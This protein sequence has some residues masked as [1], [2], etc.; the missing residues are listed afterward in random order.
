MAFN[1]RVFGYQGL[2]QIPLINPRQYSADSV[3]QLIQPYLWGQTVS[4]SAV[5]ASTSAQPDQDRTTAIAIEV[6]DGQAIRYEINPPNRTGGAVTAN[7]NSPILSGRNV[8]YFRPGWTVSMVD[9][10]G[11]P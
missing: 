5:A 10:T 2:E 9:A 1:V 11:L 6:P 8:M 3:M 4:V 7:V